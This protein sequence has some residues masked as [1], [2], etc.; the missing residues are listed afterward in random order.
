MRWLVRGLMAFAVLIVLAALI[1]TVVWRASLAQRSGTITVAGA[2]AS[3][4]IRRDPFGVPHIQ[5]DSEH[6]AYFALGFV[7]AQD[8]LFQMDFH[9]RLGAGRL[10]E[11]MGEGTLDIDRYMRLLGFYRLAEQA[12]GALDQPTRDLLEAYAKGVNAGIDDYGWLLPLEFLVL[13]YRPE[14]WQPAD[15][16]VWQ[17][18]MALDLS[19]NY[20]DELRNAAL[21]QQPTVSAA[22]LAELYPRDH[23]D[24]PITLA[25]SDPLDQALRA[26]DLPSLIASLPEEPSSGLG[27]NAWT[28]GAEHTVN[29]API[30][31]ND[32]H[33]RLRLPALW[34][35]A[36]LQAPGLNVVGGTMP[37]MPVVVIGRNERIAW[38]FTNTGSDTQDVFVERLSEG[39]PGHYDTPDGPRPFTSHVE[40][41]AV[42]GQRD[43]VPFTVRYSRHGPVISDLERFAA[44]AP[45]G[46]VLALAWTALAPDDTTM[47]AG[48]ALAKAQDWDGFV[49][50]LQPYQTPQQNI[51]YADVDGHI[52]IYTPAR[53]PIRPRG[54]G[55]LPAEGWSGLDDW[56]GYLPE[57]ALP[58]LRDPAEGLIVNANNRLVPDDYPHFLAASWSPPH[59]ARLIRDGLDGGPHSAAAMSALQNDNRSAQAQSVLPSLLDIL[60]DQDDARVAALNDWDHDMRADSPAPLIFLTWY[61]EFVRALLEDESGELFGSV[62]G[63][64]LGFSENAL[65]HGS[66]WCD[67]VTTDGEESCADM[68]QLAWQRASAQLDAAYG[69]DGPRAADWHRLHIARL[70]HPVFSRIPGLRRLFAVTLHAGGDA[71]AINVGQSSLFS[72]SEP[73]TVTHAAGYRAVYDLAVPA[74]QAVIAGGQSGHR[75]SHHHDDLASL[76]Q[77][78]GTIELPLAIEDVADTWP[79]ALILQP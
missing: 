5:A 66:L 50:A 71:S 30:L 26:L 2:N 16:L 24:E 23:A 45:Q 1:G 29:G 59:R 76:W 38:G 73:F 31:A 57:V 77:E 40:Q 37:A 78:G 32:P 44:D 75:L 15:S 12:Y 4:T 13:R 33:L 68:V 58:R 7:H 72:A 11:V 27:S 35:L 69:A 41:I 54:Q 63:W 6:D 47:A 8:R 53:V 49:A 14:P 17:K 64:R 20:R 34:Y 61:R 52:G 9:R 67:R 43:P 21:L 70:E 60:G 56:Q 3:I 55:L 74:A 46:H 79:A 18:L 10:S 28:L 65:M 62:A 19:E 22:H 36:H 42:R 25:L 51:Q 48:F 39:R